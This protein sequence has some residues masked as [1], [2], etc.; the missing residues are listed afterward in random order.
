MI[1]SYH[2]TILHYI[3]FQTDMHVDKNNLGFID[4]NTQFALTTTAPVTLTKD[5]WEP[6]VASLEGLVWPLPLSWLPAL[7]KPLQ[8]FN[9]S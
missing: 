3:I 9:Y 6:I 2:H 7:R 8:P 5:S 4:S 1:L